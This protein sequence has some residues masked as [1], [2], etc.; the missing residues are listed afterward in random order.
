MP[1]SD[2]FYSKCDELG[3]L[4][5]QEWPTCWD[6]PKT[7]PCEELVETVVLNTVRIRN[8]PSLV[9]W[10][11]GNELS[12]VDEPSMKKMQ[13]LAV[14][15]DG[16]RPF[17]RTS[18]YAGSLH[19]YDTYWMMQDM[20]NAINLRAPF[21]G[22]FGMASC[23]NIESVARYV[24]AEELR[25]P[26]TRDAKT[27]F[28]Y[29]TPRFNEFL[30]PEQYNDMDHLLMRSKEFFDIKTVED[31]ILGTQLAPGVAIC[32]TL[33]AQ[34]ADFPKAAGICYYKLTDVYP[35]CSWSTVD[36]YGVPKI[37]Y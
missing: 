37:S 21:I 30:W 7:Q 1:E 5:Q 34:R 20:D 11:G 22:E 32:H 35:A 3:L 36:Y 29:H 18:P 23:P 27:G 19:N 14:S 4:V 17:H 28:N 6:S 9:R 26:I 15:L 31:F 13:E 16:S 10:A 33:E 8:H 12:A 24:P 25:E 2:Y